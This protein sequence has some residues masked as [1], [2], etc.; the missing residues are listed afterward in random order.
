M[1][2]TLNTLGLLKLR[3]LAYFFFFH[4]SFPSCSSSLVL[5]GIV[6]FALFDGSARFLRFS[7]LFND[8][9]RSNKKSKSS[10]FS[11]SSICCTS[12]HSFIPLRVEYIL[13]NSFSIV[14]CVSL[15]FTAINFFA[16][17]F[18]SSSSNKCIF[19]CNNSANLLFLFCSVLSSSGTCRSGGFTGLFSGCSEDLFSRVKRESPIIPNI[20]YF[21]FNCFLDLLFF[22]FALENLLFLGTESLLLFE[23]ESLFLLLLIS[24][25]CYLCVSIFFPSFFTR[26]PSRWPST[27]GSSTR[28]C[29]HI[30]RLRGSR[31]TDSSKR[32]PPRRTSWP[33]ATA[34]AQ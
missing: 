2:Q 13:I 34:D 30:Q 18:R 25:G 24:S 14:S 10:L 9:Y 29:R 32:I 4:I 16:Y 6:I 15:S 27:T 1:K 7:F 3:R 20:L 26:R 17:C 8:L 28:E 12:S 11:F 23:P 33:Q 31:C 5:S 19:F 22:L 21:F